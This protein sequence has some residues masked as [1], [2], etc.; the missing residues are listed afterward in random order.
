MHVLGKLEII[1]KKLIQIKSLIY[2]YLHYDNNRKKHHIKQ[3]NI[4]TKDD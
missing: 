2:Y 4:N 1:Y 3:Y